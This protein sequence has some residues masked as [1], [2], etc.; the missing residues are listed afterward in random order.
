MTLL[1]EVQQARQEALTALLAAPQPEGGPPPQ[2]APAKPRRRTYA[3]RPLVADD[4]VV[5]AAQQRMADAAELR[6]AWKAQ[7]RRRRAGDGCVVWWQ[8]P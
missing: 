4:P 6:A 1:A 3:K 8:H 7:P 5:L 2:P